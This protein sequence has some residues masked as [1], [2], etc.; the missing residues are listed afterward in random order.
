MYKIKL[1][2]KI[3][4]VGLDKF[5]KNYTYD[6]DLENED[7]V[8]VR[9]ANLHEYKINDNLKAIARAGAGVNNI[10]LD[11]CAAA[12]V[13]V[14]NTPG[15]N[16]NAVKELVLC[17][18]LISSRKI[19][20]AVDWA[21]DLDPEDDPAKKCEKGKKQFVGPEI[22]G[23][24]L[25]VIGLGAI[26]IKVANA[27]T[28]L[29]MDVYGYDPYISVKNAWSL[30]KQINPVTTVE[31]IY[32]NCDYISIHIPAIEKT[33]G[34][35]NKEAFDQMKDGVKVINFARGSLVNN[36]DMA[37]ALDSGKVGKYV[38]DFV[39]GELMGKEN[40]IF[41]PHLG[42]STYESEENCAS[43]AVDQLTD[44]LENGNIVNSVNFPRCVQARESKERI[45]II[46]ENIPNILA[47]ISTM[48]AKLGLNI[49]NMVNRAKGDYAYTLI[50]TNDT[51]DESMLKK[52]AEI[53]GIIKV[54]EIK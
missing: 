53:E 27:A 20:E 34:F 8:I 24:K 52:I 32:K 35:L 48:F 47:S 22:A 1:L 38:S 46:N 16:A 6:K 45:C 17:G 44:F 28:D 9:S 49:E 5:D 30:N 14:F 40:I 39:A 4:N 7:A 33:K 13:V 11:K 51:V 3:S 50:D 25:G 31:E 23:K 37:Q 43:M 41:I 19:V 36:I 21:K 26:G 29:E 18:L 54:R 15:A 42:A 12:G 10:P 2:D